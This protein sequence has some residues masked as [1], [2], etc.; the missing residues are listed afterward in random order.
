LQRHQL[1]QLVDRLERAERE[2][3]AEPKTAAP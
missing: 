1:R 2:R 3:E